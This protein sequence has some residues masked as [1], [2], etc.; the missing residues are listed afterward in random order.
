VIPVVV[1][2]SPISHPKQGQAI[3]SLGLFAFCRR[4]IPTQLR[5]AYPPG[6]QEIIC[7]LRTSNQTLAMQRL[8]RRWPRP[9][10]S[11]IVHMLDLALCT[12]IGEGSM[13][14]LVAPDSRRGEVSRQL[15]R[16]AF[17]MA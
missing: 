17:S 15:K 4:R 16:P 12:T 2:S 1:G 5:D 13:L 8:P 6:K 3:D 7:S 14:F 10:Y 9:I 11:G